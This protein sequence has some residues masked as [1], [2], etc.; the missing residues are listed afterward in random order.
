MKKTKVR[1]YMLYDS[2]YIKFR[3]RKNQSTKLEV[4][5]V[6]TQ[7]RKDNIDHKMANRGL[8]RCL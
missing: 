3:T 6:V 8:L 2:L 4:R 7:D 1:E 5:T